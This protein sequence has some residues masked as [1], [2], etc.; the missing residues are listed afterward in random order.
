MKGMTALQ[1]VELQSRIE[2]WCEGGREY[3]NNK[4]W[5]IAVNRTS[6]TVHYYK[7]PLTVDDMTLEMCAEETSKNPNWSK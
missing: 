3:Y 1:M 4:R 7:D 6:S 5:G 2:L